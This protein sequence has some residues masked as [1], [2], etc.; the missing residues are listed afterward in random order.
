LHQL[1]VNGEAAPEQPCEVGRAGDTLDAAL[2]MDLCDYMPGDILVK[3]DRAS[4]AHGLE[5]RTPYL[6]VDF[7]SFCISLPT[8]LK[9]TAREEK[10]ILRRSYGHAWTEKIR[11]RK[12]CGFGAPVDQWLKRDS[13]MSL[14]GRILNDSAHA[15]FSLVPFKAARP[16]IERDNYQTWALLTLGLWLEH[17]GERSL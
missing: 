17:G 10:W 7:A 9:I 5:L 14:K 3:T 11:A 1:S 8:R 16:F 13:V 12:K 4:M 6:D 2:R 15:L